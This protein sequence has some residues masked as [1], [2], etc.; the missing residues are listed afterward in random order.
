MI[1]DQSF[2]VPRW[3]IGV[4]AIG[5]SGEAL[6]IRS[7]LENL[8]A[9]V[10]LHLPGTPG[11]FLTLLGQGRTPYEYVVISGH[12]DA[13]G[14]VF[15]HY[16]E[17]IDV[18][19]LTNGR[20]GPGAIAARIDLPDRIVVSTA[21]ETGSAAFGTAFLR[22]NLAAYV[23]PSGS[24]EGCDAVLFVHRFFHLVL[25]RGLSP[26]AAA[27]GAGDD[28]RDGAFVVHGDPLRREVRFN[29]PNA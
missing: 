26:R 5:D 19:A 16:A 24:P 3:P 20:L 8:G 6:L 12:G 9:S 11:D 25:K 14:F 4:I 10:T 17:M 2:F 22:G 7:L 23:A 15:G 27:E 21:C 18:S 29:R 13:G 28:S 1:I